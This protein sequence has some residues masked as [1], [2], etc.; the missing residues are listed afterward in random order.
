LYFNLK[1]EKVFKDL[2]VNRFGKANKNKVISIYLMG[3]E[4]S[5]IDTY[6][7]TMEHERQNRI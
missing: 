2:L 5:P 3:E 4:N 1:T 7:G 6:S